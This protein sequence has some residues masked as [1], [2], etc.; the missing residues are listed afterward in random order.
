[1]NTCFKYVRLQKLE[2]RGD[3]LFDGGRDDVVDDDR[4]SHCDFSIFDDHILDN[5][6]EVVIVLDEVGEG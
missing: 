3:V 5:S 4:S 1:M 6:D 2:G